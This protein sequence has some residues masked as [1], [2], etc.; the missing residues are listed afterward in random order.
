MQRD[1]SLGALLR[2]GLSAGLLAGS[3]AGWPAA[4][5]A[6]TPPTV[7]PAPASSLPYQARALVAGVRFVGNETTKEQFIQSQLKTRKDREFDPEVVQADVRRLA[8]TGRFHKVDTYTQ[9]TPEGILVTFAFTERMSIREIKYL[10]NR[11][12]NDKTLAKQDGLEIG[13]SLTPYAVEEGRRKIEE[14]YHSKGFGKTQVAILEGDQS[15][16]GRVVF[17]I[18]EGQL[19]RIASVKFVGNTIATDERLKTQIKSK[20]GFLWYLFKGQVDRKQIDEDIE[21]LTAY[22]RALGFFNARIGRELQFSESGQW[23]TLTFVIDEGPRYV[24]R[25]V[26][27]AGNEK[28]PTQTLL[29]QMELK[30]GDYFN[31]GK[32]NRDANS[33]RDIYGG[34]GHIFADI[35]ADPRFLEEPGQLDLV[36]NVKEGGVWRASRV[37]VHIEGEHPHTREKV[38]LNRLSVR[39]GDILDTRELRASERRLKAS[40]LFQNDPMTGETPQVVVR[41]PELQDA[42]GNVADGEGP[43]TGMYRGQSP[44]GSY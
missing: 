37:N 38:V 23:L 6:Q 36:Y 16:D 17:V 33:L 13:D 4:G 29:D 24:V 43:R 41:P 8:T 32:M 44:G 31:L 22:Y 11:N 26:T 35:Q 2:W 34:Q 20:P 1:H 39:P 27:V 40:Q 9:E 21:R 30:S 5:L 12:I 10:G 15:P 7:P 14:Y 19:E 3:F 25:N 18:N 28:F 42:V